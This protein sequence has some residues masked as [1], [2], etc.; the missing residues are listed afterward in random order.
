MLWTLMESMKTKYYHSHYHADNNRM[1]S[2]LVFVVCSSS[3]LHRKAPLKIT[4]KEPG[5]LIPVGR[6]DM[7]TSI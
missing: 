7:I 5:Q 4:T 3:Q 1:F 6:S 2:N